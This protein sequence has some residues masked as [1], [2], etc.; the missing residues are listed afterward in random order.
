MSGGPNLASQYLTGWR[1]GTGPA[2]SLSPSPSESLLGK[3]SGSPTS[4]HSSLSWGA[5]SSAHKDINGQE[6]RETGLAAQPSER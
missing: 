5:T 3:C 2:P 1:T 4:W 6:A